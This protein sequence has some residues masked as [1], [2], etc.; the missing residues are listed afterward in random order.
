M[1]GEMRNVVLVGKESLKKPRR[2]WK[3]NTRMDLKNRL[4]R[5]GID[6]FGSRQGPVAGSYEHGNES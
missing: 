5:S 6:S 1:H 3:K 4:G 2:R